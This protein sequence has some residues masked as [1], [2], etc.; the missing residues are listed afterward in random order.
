MYRNVQISYDYKTVSWNVIINDEVVF[1]SYSK[2][3]CEFF[4]DTYEFED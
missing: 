1:T 2:E 3:D 4:A